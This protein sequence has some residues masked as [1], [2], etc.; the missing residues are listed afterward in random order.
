[1]SVFRLQN[2]AQFDLLS[3]FISIHLVTGQAIF[4]PA[5]FLFHGP[6]GTVF[7]DVYTTVRMVFH[8]PG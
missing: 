4:R 8:L 5:G 1:V 7:C 3:Y 2:C 6:N